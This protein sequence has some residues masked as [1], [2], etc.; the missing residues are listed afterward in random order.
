MWQHDQ[1]DDH[2][3]ILGV[4]EEAWYE[5]ARMSRHAARYRAWLRSQGYSYD[6]AAARAARLLAANEAAPPP[7]SP[8]DGATI[9]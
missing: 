8:L 7:S 3:E 1:S 5:Q 9:H 6:E 2:S 4:W